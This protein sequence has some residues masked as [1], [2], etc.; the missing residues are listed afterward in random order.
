MLQHRRKKLV[1]AGPSGAFPGQ[2]PPHILCF[3]SSLRYPDKTISCIFLEFFQ[4][5]KTTTEWKKLSAADLRVLRIKNVT[6]V[7]LPCYLTINQSENCISWS[8][9]LQPCTHALNGALKM[10][11]WEYHCDSVVTN[12]ASIHE[13]VGLIP[14]LNQCVKDPALPWAVV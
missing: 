10:F 13:D 11:C 1:T 6:L 8:H 4:I 5:L 2:V 12:P 14:G 3:S 7:T 9:F